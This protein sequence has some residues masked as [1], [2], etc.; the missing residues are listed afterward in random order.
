MTVPTTI[1]PTKKRSGASKHRADDSRPVINESGIKIKTVYTAEDLEASGGVE[2]VGL[3]GQY[4]FTRG[5]HKEMYRKRPW[6]MRQYTGFGNP[7]DTNERFKFLI[8]NGQTG[9]NVAFDL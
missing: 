9:L 6:T 7:Q 3:P 5:I 4:P 2:M 1:R 8:E